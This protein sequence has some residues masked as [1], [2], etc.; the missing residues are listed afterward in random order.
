VR[1][2]TYQVALRGSNQDS[3]N[4]EG[5]PGHFTNLQN[6]GFHGETE[7]R[8][9]VSRWCCFW[10]WREKQHQKRHHYYAGFVRGSPLTEHPH[11]RMLTVNKLLRPFFIKVY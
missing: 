7:R 4:P 11:T 6:V 9:S 8:R 2:M 10:G 3:S 1:S 5:P